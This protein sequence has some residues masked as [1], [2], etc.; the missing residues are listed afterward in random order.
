METAGLLNSSTANVFTLLSGLTGPRRRPRAHSRPSDLGS[1]LFSAAP[2]SATKSPTARA[3]T[4][5]PHMCS[6]CRTPAVPV[7]GCLVPEAVL[8]VEGRVRAGLYGSRV[9][10]RHPRDLVSFFALAVAPMRVRAV[11]EDSLGRK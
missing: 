10:S 2:D 11:E 4:Y 7:S 9:T 5:R 6:V 3:I 8:T 1:P